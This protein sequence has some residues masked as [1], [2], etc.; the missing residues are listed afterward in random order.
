MNGDSDTGVVTIGLDGDKILIGTS[1]ADFLLGGSGNDSLTGGA[2]NDTLIGEAGVNRYVYTDIAWGAD[3]I[4]FFGE[5][6]DKIDFTSVSTIHS[7]SDFTMHEWD[8][9]GG[10]LSTT[11]FHTD[12]ATTSAITLIGVVMVDVL[13]SDFLFA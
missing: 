9:G 8:T 10:S 1:A 7:L 4:F 6:T 3:T 12:G 5:H 13:A 11:L 2:G